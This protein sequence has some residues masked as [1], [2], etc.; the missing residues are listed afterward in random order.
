MPLDT[1]ISMYPQAYQ[2]LFKTWPWQF[3]IERVDSERPPSV[4]GAKAE[5]FRAGDRQ[6]RDTHY[7][8]HY[9]LIIRIIASPF[10][11][12]ALTSHVMDALQTSDKP[13]F[14]CCLTTIPADSKRVAIR[15]TNKSQTLGIRPEA[16]RSRSV[17]RLNVKM[18]SEMTDRKD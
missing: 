6:I 1:P 12:N 4:S 10:I 7:D 14:S 13:A 3:I 11:W 2:K 16:E 17:C 15:T 9:P 5:Q 18:L 8:S